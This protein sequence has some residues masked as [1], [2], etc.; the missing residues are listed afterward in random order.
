MRGGFV[1]PLFQSTRPPRHN[2]SRGRQCRRFVDALKYCNFSIYAPTQ[3]AT[4]N[5]GKYQSVLSFQSTRPH[6][7]RLIV[8]MYSARM[9]AFQSMRPRR[10]RL[11]VR[12]Y[13]ARVAAFQSMRPRRARHHACIGLL[14]HEDVSIHAPT[15]GAT[16]RMRSS[17]FWRLFQSTRPR[18][19]RHANK[20]RPVDA[21]K[22]SIHAPTQGATLSTHQ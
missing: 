12:M 15:Q 14:G 17:L 3:G 21:N 19:A 4:A 8:R 6:R 10:A 22:V 1:A 16:A 5:S 18:R 9:A 20:H 7:A 2:L 13:S 11:I